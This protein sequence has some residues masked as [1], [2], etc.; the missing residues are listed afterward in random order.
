MPHTFDDDCINHNCDTCKH[1][2]VNAP[3]LPCRKCID[4]DNICYWE[5]REKME[6]DV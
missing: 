1:R 5:S 3:E 4:R 2:D 6:E